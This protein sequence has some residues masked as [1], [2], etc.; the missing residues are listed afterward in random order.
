MTLIAFAVAL[1]LT[2]VTTPVIASAYARRGRLDIPNLRSSHAAR[3][4]RGPAIACLSGVAGGLLVARPELSALPVAGL[5]AVSLFTLVGYLDDRLSLPSWL[6]LLIQAGCGA[7]AGAAA[8]GLLWVVGGLV[9]VVVLVNCVNVMDGIN[10]I[11]SLT[12]IVWGATAAV[13]GS[14]HDVVVLHLVGLLTA[15]VASVSIRW[16]AGASG[17]HRAGSMS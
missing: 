12:M 4:P 8:G 10:G 15:A 17:D 1:V 3:V 9:A 6:R 14:T 16:R 5:A 13:L 2:F 11:T 7:A